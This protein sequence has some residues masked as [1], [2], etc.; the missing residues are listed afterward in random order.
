M[1]MVFVRDCQAGWQVGKTSSS[2]R[3]GA[4]RLAGG[5]FAFFIESRAGPITSSQSGGDL[6]RC[7]GGVTDGDFAVRRGQSHLLQVFPDWRLADEAKFDSEEGPGAGDSCLVLGMA[8]FMIV[9]VDPSPQLADRYAVWHDCAGEVKE[10][11]QFD[12]RRETF[13]VRAGS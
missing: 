1:T 6:W 11:E 2:E 13:D 12:G 3:G 8:K 4:V 5:R 9:V 7:V 10:A